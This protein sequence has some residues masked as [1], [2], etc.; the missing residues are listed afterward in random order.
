MDFDDLEEAEEE[1]GVVYEDASA[2]HARE[3]AAR[4]QAEQE[5]AEARAAQARAAAEARR[6][7]HEAREAAR[8][9]VD[10]ARR[11]RELDALPPAVEDYY[12][13]FRG[14]CKKCPPGVCDVYVKPANPV[15]QG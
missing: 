10:A 9:A 13:T 4:R 5:A 11:Q 14:R 15:R 8:E 12:G 1:Q 2:R 3:E 6:K 7:E